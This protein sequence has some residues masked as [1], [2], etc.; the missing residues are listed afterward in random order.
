MA[1]VKFRLNRPKKS[2]DPTSI[3][4]RFYSKQTGPLDFSTG[5]MVPPMYWESQRVSSK[6]RKNH[7]R[8][9]KHLSKIECDLLDVWRDNKAAS[10]EEL[11]KLIRDSVKGQIQPGQKKTVFE[12]LT[13]FIAQYSR[14]KEAR[15]VMSYKALQAKLTAFN[16]ELSFEMLDFNF[17]DAFKKFLYLNPN[18]LY[19]GF[20]LVYDG[21]TG[22]HTVS[23]GADDLHPIGLFDDVVFKYFIN[24][25]VVCSWAEKR[26]YQV[27]SSYKTWPIIK[28][29]YPIISLTLDELQRIENLESLPRHLTLAKDYL[30]ICCR[31]GQRISD[32]KRISFLSIASGV[33]TIFQ[34]KGARIKQ[35]EIHLP[36][37]GFCAPVINIVNKYGGQLPV[38]SEQKLNK[39]IKEVCKRAGIN[40]EIY[41]ERWAGSKKIRIP[42][43]K[44]D[45]ISCH[46]GK[47]SFVTI[48]GGMG[49]PIKIISDLTGTSIK[50]IEKHYLGKTD[51]YVVDN[52]L[53][54][55]ENNQLRKAN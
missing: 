26:D 17:Y 18:P 4:V 47:R 42:G 21:N 43:Q 27:N 23:P 48:L 6:Y 52:Y 31:T 55:I 14:E 9:N 5:E 50:T 25:K 44:Y 13:K 45:F 8:I 10:G 28:R 38:I 34:K 49:V 53:K 19:K 16:P 22:L 20:H 41:I 40:Q 7:D 30:S 11:K 46:S 51:L 37:V 33:W 39:H 24:L 35:K 54:G 12:A 3:I 15:T 32:V 36:L 2:D 29:E 1:S